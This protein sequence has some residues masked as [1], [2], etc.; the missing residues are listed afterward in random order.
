MYLLKFEPTVVSN[1]AI[2]VILIFFEIHHINALRRQF[3]RTVRTP[4]NIEA[5]AANVRENLLTSTRHRSQELNISRPILGS[6]FK[7]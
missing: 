5:V 2:L 4:A 1:L 3:A 6:W 7:S